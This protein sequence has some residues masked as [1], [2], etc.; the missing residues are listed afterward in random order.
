VSQKYPSL[1]FG[2]LKR[3]L[4]QILP[5]GLTFHRL[6]VQADGRVRVTAILPPIFT[7]TKFN[8]AVLPLDEL[9]IMVPDT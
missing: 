2:A 3:L 5:R 4:L 6:Y 9:G 1:Q 7:C 8:S